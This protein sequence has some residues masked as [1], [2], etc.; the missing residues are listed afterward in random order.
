MAEHV[1]HGHRVE[2]AGEERA[3]GVAEVMEAQRREAGG[4]A[5]GDEA[6]A[7]R[8][9]VGAVTGDG[10]EHIV[11]GAREVRAARQAVERAE[12]LVA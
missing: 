7:E 10:R 9:R 2:Y 3:G 5:R 4:V 11:V 8:R 1:A 12:R 6:A